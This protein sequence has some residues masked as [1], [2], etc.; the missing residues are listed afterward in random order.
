[1]FFC[2]NEPTYSNISLCLISWESL[3]DFLFGSYT[4]IAQTSS[5][6]LTPPTFTSRRPQLGSKVT[7]W[8]DLARLATSPLSVRG[9]TTL[10]IWRSGC[11]FFSYSDSLSLSLSLS[12]QLCLWEGYESESVGGVF[13]YQPQA[14]RR[15]L[16]EGLARELSKLMGAVASDPTTSLSLLS[17]QISP[18]FSSHSRSQR[19]TTHH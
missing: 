3:Q 11:L 12:L 19:S 17:S 1:M 2:N 5:S 13:L 16:V 18:P 9:W 10:A 4:S 15:D 7:A 14:L 8:H 6:C